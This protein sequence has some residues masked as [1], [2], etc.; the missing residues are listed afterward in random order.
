MEKARKGIYETWIV[1]ALQEVDSKKEWSVQKFLF[2]GKS[3][4]DKIGKKPN[5]NV[6]FYP[7]FMLVKN[8]DG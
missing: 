4:W 5:D 7:R 2:W 8:S 1:Q 6:G 3:L